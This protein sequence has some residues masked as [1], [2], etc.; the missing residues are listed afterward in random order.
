MRYFVKGA[1]FSIISLILIF[2]LISLFRPNERYPADPARAF[3]DGTLVDCR[4]GQLL[5]TPQVVD[6][7]TLLDEEDRML[8]TA[9]LPFFFYGADAVLFVHR[10]KAPPGARSSYGYIFLRAEKEG[11][12]AWRSVPWADYPFNEALRK[13][14]HGK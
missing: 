10:Q 6:I 12:C 4:D 8:I 2:A 13:K 1:V 5:F 11:Y 9:H 3:A 14:Y 7:A